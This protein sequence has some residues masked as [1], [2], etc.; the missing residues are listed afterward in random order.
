MTSDIKYL[1]ID[2]Q[3]LKKFINIYGISAYEKCLCGSGKNFKF[4]CWGKHSKKDESEIKEWSS[5]IYGNNLSKRDQNNCRCLYASCNSRAINSHLFSKGT[6]IKFMTG[7]YKH[8]NRYTKNIR[9]GKYVAFYHRLQLKD[10]TT[11]KGFC[12]IHD[13]SL[14]NDIDNNSILNDRKLYALTYRCIGYHLR[15]LETTIRVLLNKHY[16]EAP[17]FYSNEVVSETKLDLQA[18]VIKLYREHEIQLSSMRRLLK[19]VEKNYDPKEAC[20]SVKHSILRFSK[21]IH[22]EITDPK[23]LFNNVQLRVLA[24]QSDL[25]S[26]SST[27]GFSLD[28][29]ITMVLPNKELEG[30]DVV[31]AT[32]R[33]ASEK[34]HNFVDHIERANNYEICSILN[35]LIVSNIDEFYFTEDLENYIKE[36]ELLH[37]IENL[38]QQPHLLQFGDFYFE[39]MAQKPCVELL[40]LKQ[41]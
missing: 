38:V 33:G 39:K 36:K 10:A 29:I 41:P 4:C 26:F 12:S 37:I 28:H 34:C 8:I 20:W 32:H 11:F 17:M 7:K 21:P 18:Y 35:N 24:D 5:I 27:D 13:N 23:I 16:K 1:N 14:F 3:K 30:I 19:S 22:I 25:L 40:R 6:H 15:K 9:N 31:F 2:N